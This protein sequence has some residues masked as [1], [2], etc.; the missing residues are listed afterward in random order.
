MKMARKDQ[1]IGSDHALIFRPSNGP[2]GSML[3]PPNIA[4][5]TN[6]IHRSSASSDGLEPNITTS[7][8]AITHRSK[9]VAGPARE[10][11]PFCLRSTC[12]ATITAPGAMNK[13]PNNAAIISPFRKPR[14]SARN[15]AQ[16]PKR[17]ADHLCANSCKMKAGPK[18]IDAMMKNR[19][20]PTIIDASELPSILN[21]P[22]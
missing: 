3:N 19:I 7:G 1:N 10:I 15:S 18:A 13:K 17:R 16:Q 8:N 12:P 14:G 21:N 6:H 4:F 9:F 11:M 2:N 20:V 5:A 22:P